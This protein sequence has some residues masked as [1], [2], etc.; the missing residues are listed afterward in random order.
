M[1]FLVNHNPFEDIDS[2]R[3]IVT[4][5]IDTEEINCHKALAVGTQRVKEID[6][7]NF[8]IMK[9]TKKTK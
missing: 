1:Q 4:G 7:V 6:G 2:L 3:N 8:H 9:Q 5:L